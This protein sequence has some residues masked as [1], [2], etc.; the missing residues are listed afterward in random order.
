MTML[1]HNVP[2]K[3]LGAD[4]TA[5]ARSLVGLLRTAESESGARLRG[6]EKLAAEHWSRQAIE[7]VSAYLEELESAL[8]RRSPTELQ[9]AASQLG[10]VSRY[11]NDYDYS[12]FTKE[13]D[14]ARALSA[15]D[16]AATPIMTSIR[17]FDPRSLEAARRALE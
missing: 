9:H 4:L 13:E 11:V 7:N 15:L 6:P 3:Q 14:L 5:L 1:P 17:R 12:W 2:L 10:S 16:N 8:R